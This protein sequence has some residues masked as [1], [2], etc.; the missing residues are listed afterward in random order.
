MGRTAANGCNAA[1]PG[2]G[3]GLSKATKQLRARLLLALEDLVPLSHQQPFHAFLPT[4]PARIAWRPALGPAVFG[5]SNPM[6]TD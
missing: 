1:G 5:S 3:P 4:H 6:P 2:T